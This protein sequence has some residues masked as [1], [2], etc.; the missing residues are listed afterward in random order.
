MEQ[1]GLHHARKVRLAVNN[2]QSMK[3]NVH[4]MPIKHVEVKV[5]KEELINRGGGGGVC[6]GG[7]DPR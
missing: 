2:E 1:Y 4:Q 6:E 5:H 7:G 3:N